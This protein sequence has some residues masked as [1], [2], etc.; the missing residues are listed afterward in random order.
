MNG[1]RSNRRAVRCGIRK[2][3]AFSPILF[4]LAFDSA[5]WVI[6]KRKDVRGVP[7]TYYGRTTELKEMNHADDTAVYLRDRSVVKLVVRILEDFGSV[8]DLLKIKLTPWSLNST[9][10][11]HT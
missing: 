1:Y 9:I 4:I 8:S 11:D 2:G 6:Q 7:L 10:A 3:Y 5:F